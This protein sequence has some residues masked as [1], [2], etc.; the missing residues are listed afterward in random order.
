[1]IDVCEFFSIKFFLMIL[2][3]YICGHQKWKS[4]LTVLYLFCVATNWRCY[5]PWLMKCWILFTFFPGTATLQNPQRTLQNPASN[6]KPRRKDPSILEKSKRDRQRSCPWTSGRNASRRLRRSSWEWRQW[7]PEWPAPRPR[8][9]PPQPQQQRHLQRKTR[10][11]SHP[12]PFHKYQRSWLRNQPWQGFPMNQQHKWQ[13]R[14]LPKLQQVKI[15]KR[16]LLKTT[17]IRSWL[18]T[19]KSSG[20]WSWCPCC[21][22][23]GTPTCLLTGTPRRC[24]L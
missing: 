2:Q 16:K 8:R 20:T 13:A 19:T 18:S 23:R 11:R 12:S 10:P 21:R 15:N 7:L 24:Q 6:P 1:M 3:D 22:S 14:E 4:L 9:P 17:K 5:C